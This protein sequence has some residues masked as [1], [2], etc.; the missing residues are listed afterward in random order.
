[1]L[2]AL[3]T[4]IPTGYADFVFSTADR[5]RRITSPQISIHSTF[6][7]TPLLHRLASGCPQPMSTAPQQLDSHFGHL[8][9]PRCRW[10]LKSS[11]PL[12]SREEVEEV[13]DQCWS[14][15]F[16]CRDP[17]LFAKIRRR[18]AILSTNAYL[19][20]WSNHRSRYWPGAEC[21]F[22][23]TRAKVDASQ[24][25]AYLRRRPHGRGN[26]LSSG[27]TGTEGRR[28]NSNSRMEC[29]G[30][31]R[32]C[33]NRRTCSTPECRSATGCSRMGPP[34]DFRPTSRARFGLTPAGLVPRTLRGIR[35][36]SRWNSCCRTTQF[37][38]T[39][40][41]TRRHTF[42]AHQCSACV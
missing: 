20:A 27:S 38:L 1:M 7:A 13:P 5:A 39:D 25:N 9:E 34:P 11:N 37:R 31:N 14:G 19:D 29:S 36:R 8:H 24:P 32:R 40:S 30:R 12:S 17:V 41:R 18:V 26:C 28:L 10:V 2:S 4:L 21:A 6:H 42:P 33:L 3:T 22:R 15:T 23:R 16:L 35:P